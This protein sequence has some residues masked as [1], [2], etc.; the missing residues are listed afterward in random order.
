MNHIRH[1]AVLSKN[2][3]SYAHSPLL[4]NQTPDWLQEKLLFPLFSLRLIALIPREHNTLMKPQSLKGA[5]IIL[6]HFHRE[7]K[8]FNIRNIKAQIH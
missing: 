2:S 4:S 3:D 8:N 1:F 6:G 5:R 7:L